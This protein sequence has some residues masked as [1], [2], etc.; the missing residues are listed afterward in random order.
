MV[1][2]E[3]L[4]PLQVRQVGLPV[5]IP[6]AKPRAIL[7]MLGLHDGSVVSADALVELLWGDDPPRTAAKA[8]Q[9]HISL[10]R[11][12]LGEGFVLTQGAGWTLAETEVDAARYKTA[13]RLGRDAAAAGDDGRAV[14]CFDEALALWRGI[15]ELPDGRR[16][17]PEKTRWIEAHACTDRRD[18]ADL[19][20]QSDGLLDACVS[21]DPDDIDA[22][23]AELDTR[24]LASEAAAHA[25]TWTLVACAYEALNRR[26]LPETTA[27][28]V[29]LDHRRLA[30]IAAGDLR[31]YLLATWD[32]SPEAGIRIAAVHRLST[33]G[34]V[35]THVV[36]GTSH[37][38]F[39]AEWRTIDLTTYEGD[40][41]DHCEIF[42]EA[43]ID[44][45]LA[46]FDELDRPT[47]G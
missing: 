44:A 34:A 24:Y 13:A 20:S 47:P 18:V 40:M 25:H 2:L 41:V 35:V 42:D 8:L 3:V 1:E 33:R 39:E 22:A 23:F 43:E 6:G 19:R 38:G 37:Q 12:N 27:D 30:P 9:T 16:G 4:G 5:A 29:N 45:A 7:T 26:E 32:L 31:E 36:K 14:V 21:F 46:R 28:W 15:P 10:L 17:T 11:R